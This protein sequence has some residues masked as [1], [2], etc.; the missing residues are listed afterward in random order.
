MMPHVSP[1]SVT[2]P[3]P[4]IPPVIV[5]IGP[6]AIRWYGVMYVVGFA[7][8][9]RIARARIARGL[10]RMGA[11]ALDPL[12]AYLV[13]GMLLGARLIYALVYD[14]PKF[15][16][17]PL[18]LVRIWE[19]GLSFHGA[20]LGMTIACALFAWRHRVPFLDVA[21]TLALA[22]TP[23]LFFG[24]LGNFINA[25]LYGRPTDVPWAMIFPTDPLGVPRHPSQLYEALGEGLALFLALR[26]L[27]RRAVGGGWYRPGLLSA[28]FLVGYGLVRFLVEFTR[29]PDRQLGLVLGPLS[30]GQVLSSTMFL[31]GLLWLVLLYR[32]SRRPR[33]AAPGEAAVSGE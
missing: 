17:D 22:G 32:R 18:A 13:V 25:E 30:M 8:G 3:Y 4:D 19:G 10:V 12:I 1:T 11:D 28:A 31:I 29:Q 6:L 33:G 7:V 24:R 23:G 26:A 9:H 16:A 2:I 21:E 14:R 15:A 5:Q 27:E 20:V